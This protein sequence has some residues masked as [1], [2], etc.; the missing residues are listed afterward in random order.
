MLIL[1]LLVSSSWGV[2]IK[3]GELLTNSLQDH[4]EVEYVFMVKDFH[5]RN[6]IQVVLSPY[7]DYSDPD[8]YAKWGSKPTSTDYQYKSESFGLDQVLVPHTEVSQGKELH[9]LAKCSARCS[10]AITLSYSEPVELFAETT[11]QGS[12]P[13][14]LPARYYYS[15]PE[16]CQGT[17]LV[18]AHPAKG[19]LQLHVAVNEQPST[20]NSCATQ[21]LWDHAQLVNTSA[22]IGDD[23]NISVYGSR[24]TEF[25]ISLSCGKSV[26]IPESFPIH[27]SV[28][29]LAFKHYRVF[30]EGLSENA[31]F[32]LNAVWGDPHLFLSFDGKP[33][34]EHYDYSSA[35]VGSDH[36]VVPKKD[37]LKKKPKWVYIGVYG[38]H[39]SDFTLLVH[40][41]NPVNLN[42]GVPQNG[43]V[44]NKQAELYFLEIPKLRDFNVTFD[45][46]A[47]A[48]N[49][50][51]YVKLCNTNFLDCSFSKE[52]LNNPENF[53]QV[54]FSST[55]DTYER[56]HIEHFKANCKNSCVYLVAVR[57]NSTLESNFILTGYYN[58]TS[59]VV[60]VQGNPVRSSVDKDM[61]KFYRLSVS[62]NEVQNIVFELTP[63]SGDPD[64]YVSRVN[65]M[66]KRTNAEK[67][68]E[69][70]G[71]T[72]DKVTF[73]K[74]E[75]GKLTANYHV[76]VRS[77]SYSSFVLVAKAVFEDL[78]TTTVLYPGITLQDTLRNTD[79]RSYKLYTFRVSSKKQL[80]LTVLEEL[81]SVKVFVANNTSAIR[82]DTFQYNWQLPQNTNTLRIEPEDPSFN[83]NGNYLVLVHAL[84][85]VQ[86]AA[87]YSI[88]F[89]L[90]ESNVP[91][92]EGLPYFDQVGKYGYNYY[93]WSINRDSEPSQLTVVVTAFYGD[94]DL[95]L[96]VNK[97]KP[98][99]S[100][101]DFKSYDN[102]G[103]T[104]TLTWDQITSKCQEGICSVYIAVFGYELAEYSVLLSTKK[105][106]PKWLL[107][108]NVQLD[109]LNSTQWNYYYASLKNS[110][111][112]EL[113]LQSVEGDSDL[114]MDIVDFSDQTNPKNWPKPNKN[115]Q[116]HSLSAVNDDRISVSNLTEYCKSSCGM[117]AGVLC[118]S[119][120][121]RYR[122]S[123]TQSK[124][125]S[126]ADN[127]PIQ[128]YVSA[129]EFTYYTFYNPNSEANILIVLTTLAGD[130]DLYVSY[131]SVPSLQSF[132]WKQTSSYGETLE[133]QNS[134]SNST[135]GTFYLGIYG[136]KESQFSLLVTTKHQPITPL[137]MS[138]PQ[139]KLTPRYSSDFF[140]FHNTVNTTLTISLNI[141]QGYGTILAS[142]QDPF[143]QEMYQRLPKWSNYTWSSLENNDGYSIV[144]DPT[145]PSFCVGCNIVIG[146]FTNSSACAYRI[147]ARN[148]MYLEVLKNGLAVR[149]YAEQEQWR[150]Y[151]FN[152][153]EPGEVEVF[154]KVYSGDPDLYISR[155]PA[156]DE[157]HFDWASVRSYDSEHIRIPSNDPASGKG[158]FYIGVRSFVGSSSFSVIAYSQNSVVTL[159]DGMPQTYNIRH[160]NLKME[161]LLG[162][163][164]NVSEL[165]CS[166][167]TFNENFKP[168][169]Y[170]NKV[171]PRQPESFPYPS[172]SEFVFETYDKVF[173]TLDFTLSYRTPGKFLFS[174]YD[175]LREVSIEQSYFSLVCSTSKQIN[176]LQQNSQHFYTQ[177]DPLN[178]VYFQVD[179]SQSSVFEVYLIPCAGKFQ[180][181]ISDSLSNLDKNDPQ[182]VIT[183]NLNGEIIGSINKAQGRY[184]VVV[185]S[186]ESYYAVE[187]AAFEVVTQTLNDGNDHR[188]I[189]DNRYITAKAL[190]EGYEF[191]WEPLSYSNGKLVPEVT[192][193]L[194]ATDDFDL[195]MGTVCGMRIGE[196][197]GIA[198]YTQTPET[199]AVLKKVKNDTVVNVAA[200]VKD[201][202]ENLNSYYA[203]YSVFVEKRKSSEGE[204]EDLVVE[205]IILVLVCLAGVVGYI[206]K[207]KRR[208]RPEGYQEFNS[209]EM[210]VMSSSS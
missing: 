21:E 93:S 136:R 202:P 115:S 67:F 78:N 104:L 174:V 130:P 159:G 171:E 106:N 176:I 47:V 52:E 62:D 178:D 112:I 108:G 138:Q 15:V 149:G 12:T 83:S 150:Y 22:I 116:F 110:K 146:V 86:E 160:S 95:F 53:D 195:Q 127:Q 25:W 77:Q 170:I 107:E 207:N 196:K 201:A 38:H 61:P 141:F 60:L 40:S 203:Y 173:G 48:G 208:P 187:G 189:G 180:V 135:K 114:Y 99:N 85:F 175:E 46:Q 31:T 182:I 41:K 161:F 164:E 79:L 96:N 118:L 158:P 156:L 20:E 155:K 8:L 11:L 188:D 163:P 168:S 45:L 2:P 191:S 128:G 197:L 152:L 89:Q 9:I 19:F 39:R 143:T 125:I 100:S 32:N 3:D 59:E 113:L 13:G 142:T 27:G 72:N 181:K 140:Y 42:A 199:S 57:G 97:P 122:I 51:M 179:V 24:E 92:Q 43:F 120:N 167:K 98:S 54:F 137:Y 124:Y 198:K 33:T 82:N 162:E 154:L 29:T 109:T 71:L 5:A 209:G 184:Y 166:V 102:G 81:G 126:V 4:G 144:I 133:I 172:A 66:P 50:D 185:S 103:D 10:F 75:D 74:G 119:S 132:D 64:I 69:G 28:G 134:T 80:R 131:E 193:L 177:K 186:L 204:D 94:P 91:L 145:D 192:Y 14:G 190:E 73:S 49:P 56:V 30:A 105:E 63:E 23:I 148:D 205:I 151:L 183:E 206:F 70:F 34:L 6:D 58:L 129:R 90:E 87:A 26:Q 101:Y 111:S 117:I 153:E 65:S 121:C 35:Q 18:E 165:Y 210:A 139:D 37:I 7:E 88:T 157:T 84:D 123:Y 194:Y 169:F 44:S 76:A 68:S 36:I 55:S 1:F 16:T 147:S 200:V 17:V